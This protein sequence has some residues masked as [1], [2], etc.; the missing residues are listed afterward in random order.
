MWRI[1]LELKSSNIAKGT[2]RR[3]VRQAITDDDTFRFVYDE[4]LELYCY[5]PCYLHSYS[6]MLEKKLNDPK[7]R[8]GLYCNTN[9]DLAEDAYSSYDSSLSARIR[10]KDLQKIVD[11]LTGEVVE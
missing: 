5:N 7:I 4:G 2:I 8:L 1:I 10:P 3:L 11:K 6:V 9:E